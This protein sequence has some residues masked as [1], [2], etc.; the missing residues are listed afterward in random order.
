MLCKKRT[1]R[2]YEKDKLLLHWKN[3]RGEY[4]KKFGIGDQSLA[5]FNKRIE[6]AM[7]TA[8]A[9][10]EGRGEVQLYI[11]IK[12]IELADMLARTGKGSDFYEVKTYIEKVLKVP[13]NEN[14]MS[15]IE[16]YTKLNMIN[17]ITD[18]E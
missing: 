17:T 10:A 5:I 16:F 9:I 12:N 8:R 14:E 6:I 13:I 11:D 7:L 3:L 1:A 15:V 4:I 18:G 2:W